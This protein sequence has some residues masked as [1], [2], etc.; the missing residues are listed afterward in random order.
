MKTTENISLAGF[1]FTIETDAY[2]S[3]GAYLG[4]IRKGFETDASADEIVADIEER[5]AELLSEK[6]KGGIV[7]NIQ[8]INEI[9]ERIGDP[10]MLA[11]EDTDPQTEAEAVQPDPH[12]KK[13]WKNKRLYRDIDERILGGVCSGLGAYFGLDKV[14]FRIIFL[15]FFLIGFLGIDEGPYFGFSLMA[16][17]CLWIAMPAARTVEQ[18]CQMKRKPIHLE[19][20]RSKEFDFGKEVKEVSESPAARTFKRAGGVFLGS[21]L[22]VIGL[23]GLLCSIMVPAMPHLMSEMLTEFT[24]VDPSEQM[25]L[26]IV[27]FKTF[28]SLVFVMCCIMF[29]WSIY[30]GVMLLFDLKYPSWRP[31]LVLL[32]AWLISIFAIFAWFIKTAAFDFPTLLFHIL[33]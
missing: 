9:K 32:I 10:K 23:G 7:V 18:K 4:E 13:N 16:Y 15:A 24:P 12:E 21:M 11:Q 17:I 33:D 28:W 22:L 1:A 30:N 6:C 27:T 14:L 3:L 26:D 29:V 25:L 19:S 8:M 5:I 20:Y 2:E 31:G